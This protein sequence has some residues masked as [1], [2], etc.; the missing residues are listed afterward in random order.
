MG[1]HCIY[2]LCSLLSSAR[3]QVG[4]GG[5]GREL[6]KGQKSLDLFYRFLYFRINTQGR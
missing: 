4:R 3:G 2:S 5:E 6:N 1:V